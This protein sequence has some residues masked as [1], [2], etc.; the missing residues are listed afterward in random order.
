MHHAYPRECV[1]P[2][3]SGTNTMM[4]E[5]EWA[6]WAGTEDVMVTPEEKQKH[7]KND[8]AFKALTLDEMVQAIPWSNVEELVTDTRSRKAPSS[9]FKK[10]RFVVG[11]MALASML[12]PL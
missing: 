10:L 5:L 6:E 1:F 12:M 7:I 9:L 3:V 8:P 11:F 4:G 2:H